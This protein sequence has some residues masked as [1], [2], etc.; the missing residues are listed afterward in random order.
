MLA[1][2]V[3]D[4][5]LGELRPFV[6]MAFEGSNQYNFS[7]SAAH[8][9]DDGEYHYFDIEG[10]FMEQMLGEESII[11]Y[12]GEFNRLYVLATVDDGEG[13]VM[14]VVACL[15]HLDDEWDYEND[16]PYLEKEGVKYYKGMSFM[17]IAKLFQLDLDMIPE[18]GSA[19]AG[20]SAATQ[21]ASGDY[22]MSNPSATGE[23]TLEDMRALYQRFL[24]MDGVQLEFEDGALEAIAE[25]ALKRNAGA[26]GLRAIIES[27][28]RNVMYDIP[29]RDDVTR[30]V[31]TEATVREHEEPQM[32]CE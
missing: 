6:G 22:G 1:R 2:I 20:G 24:E 18:E 16:Y 21:T 30:C 12:D 29:S 10:L 9:Y 17:D 19:T 3:Y 15:R 4:E 7:I 28:M 11:E 8:E 23:A 5:E 26:R 31:V 25:E 13:N 14:K 27:I 32:F